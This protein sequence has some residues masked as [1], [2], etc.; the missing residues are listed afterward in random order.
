M[1]VSF[2]S[3]DRFITGTVGQPGEREF[4]L[5]IRSGKTLL[6]MKVEKS[7]AMLFSERLEDLLKQI[8]QLNP[9]LKNIK[10][11]PDDGM[12]EQPIDNDFTIGTISLAWNEEKESIAVELFSADELLN[13]S[14]DAAPQVSFNLRIDQAKGFITRTDIIVK[15]GRLPCPFC[16]IPI[17]PRGHLCPRANGYRR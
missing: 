15:A 17:D 14:D 7:Q 12:L 13:Q 5:Q 6:S 16:A 4:F 10:H 8:F 1:N 2:E 11:I 9:L 3:I